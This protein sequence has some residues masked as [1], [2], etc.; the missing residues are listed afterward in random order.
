MPSGV[1]LE[2]SVWK[3]RHPFSRVITWHMYLANAKRAKR[4]GKEQQSWAKHPPSRSPQ[5][6][7]WFSGLVSAGYLLKRLATKAKLSL[8]LPDTTSVDVTNCLQPSLSACSSIHSALFRSSVSCRTHTGQTETAAKQKSLHSTAD[9]LT[10]LSLSAS[11]GHICLSHRCKTISFS[12]P[13][14]SEKTRDHTMRNCIDNKSAL[15]E[16]DSFGNY[17]IFRVSYMWN[18]A[19][20][21]S[22]WCRVHYSFVPNTSEPPT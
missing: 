1:F 9:K 16:P 2:V 13:W 3:K 5:L 15:L 19:E 6:M 17:T 10:N 14:V 4:D 22:K 21:E 20:F 7:S 12:I 8:G 18:S 11:M